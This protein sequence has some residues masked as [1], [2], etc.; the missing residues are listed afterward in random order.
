MRASFWVIG[1]LLAREGKARVSLPGGCAVGTRPV[2]LFI[3]ALAALGAKIEIDGGYIEATAPQGGLIGA[4][5]IF[6]NVFVC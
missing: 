1:P 3:E 5:Y 2:D 4:R 6:S